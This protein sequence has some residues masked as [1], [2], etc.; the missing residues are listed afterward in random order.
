MA[1]IRRA[2]AG[3]V[4]TGFVTIWL[5]APL[6]ALEARDFKLVVRV[7]KIPREQ[8]FEAGLLDGK[9]GTI[10]LQAYGDVTAAFPRVT[11]FLPTELAANASGEAIAAEILG[12]VVFG[13]GGIAAKKIR[14]DELKSLNL[15]LGEFHHKAEARFE[16]SRGEGRSSNYEVRAE[17]VSSEEGK[18]LIR[19]RFDAGWSSQAG[20]IG[21]GISEDVISAPVELSESKLF[22]IGAPDIK[23]GGSSSGA[24]YWLAVSALKQEL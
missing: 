22:L 8:S 7:F 11:V 2:L 13:S 12:K 4:I 10:T 1:R 23:M 3:T 18:A 15:E 16:E 9:G 5:V 17:F 21:V 24:V 14:V 20:S 19:L 6:V